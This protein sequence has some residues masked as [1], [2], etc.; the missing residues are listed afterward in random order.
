MLLDDLAWIFVTYKPFLSQSWFWICSCTIHSRRSSA[1]MSTPILANQHGHRYWW[2]HLCGWCS[3]EGHREQSR[4]ECKI[5][6]CMQN[7]CSQIAHPLLPIASHSYSHVHKKCHLSS[8]HRRSVHS[9][10]MMVLELFVFNCFPCF[11]LGTGFTD[12]AALGWV[13]H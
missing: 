11:P 3:W 12:F 5:F 2:C 7:R 13:L 6:Q 4:G 9:S 1:M 10:W 8:I